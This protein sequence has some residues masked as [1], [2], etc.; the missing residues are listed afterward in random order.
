MLRSTGAATASVLLFATAFAFA[1][2]RTDGPAD[3]PPGPVPGPASTH[4]AP[5]S[6]GLPSAASGR[7]AVG[8]AGDE[9]ESPVSAPR[10]PR[11]PV[12]Q[13]EPR[14]DFLDLGAS[15]PDIYDVRSAEDALV[16]GA[17]SAPQVLAP[18]VT[19]P[20]ESLVEPPPPPVVADDL[21]VEDVRSYSAVVSFTT[22]Q[23]VAGVVGF[24]RE[25]ATNFASGAV[26]REHRIELVGLVPDT[27][28][29]VLVVSHTGQ[30][31]PIASFTTDERPLTPEA[32]IENGTVRLDDQPFFP[33]T[34]Y[35]ACPSQL[36]N[37]LDAGV[38]VFGWDHTCGPEEHDLLES[39][40]ALDERAF[41]TLPW[42]DRDLADDG[43][44]GFTQPDEPDGLGLHPSTLPDID[45][46]GKVT[47]LT[48]TQH[49]APGTG[50]LPW[51][52]PGYYEGFVP[53]ADVF[54]VDFYPL[55]GLC[56]PE[57][58]ALNH[59]V[60][61]E[62]ARLAGGKPTFQWIETAEMNCPG[63]VDA[64]ITAET[65]RAEMLLAIAGGANGLGVFPARLD[66]S[67][68]FAVSSTLDVI[69]QAWPM[70][71][72]PR[73]PVEIGGDGASLV[74]ASARQSAGATVIVVV[75]SSLTQ[76]AAAELRLS[77]LAEGQELA[78]VDDELEVAPVEGV[79]RLELEPLEAHVLVAA[80]PG[81]EEASEAAEDDDG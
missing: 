59:D 20:P 31:R 61:V 35:G 10:A 52:Y 26:G 27:D 76:S 25:G 38:N 32:S 24:G 37:L 21:E 5:P 12:A 36:K 3:E 80:P 28:Y 15:Y 42:A 78:S 8:T 46:P 56:S 63:R 79:I 70:L 68:A 49:F 1:L 22:D 69:E 62:L 81:L 43:M 40:V 29:V 50:D 66:A 73:I 67:A 55:Q 11:G 19:D 34:A 2:A 58:L 6:P 72:T 60:Q 47:F 48:F 7:P 65:L 14:P 45:E 51:Q 77:G 53:K 23:D 57:K 33:V 75:N 9:G 64:A 30:D 39:I 74:R 44:I 41:W 54:G 18:E 16:A 4:V 13:P 71:L 17:G